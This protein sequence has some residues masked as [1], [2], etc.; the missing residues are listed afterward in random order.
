MKFATLICAAVLSMAIPA[1][2]QVATT[3][4]NKGARSSPQPRVVGNA[5]QWLTYAD[6]PGRAMREQ[7]EGTVSYKL[8]ID[9]KG[10]VSNCE[11]TSSSGHRD[12]DTLTCELLRK[13][14]RFVKASE[15]GGPRYFESRYDWKL[16]L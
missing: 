16:R 15:K 5:S 3:S 11:I 4:L 1:T 2:A 10:E 14:A 6:Y 13:R 9:A 7:R 12:L 8:T